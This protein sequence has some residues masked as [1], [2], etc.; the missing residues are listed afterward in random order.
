MRGRMR[1]CT[2]VCVCVRVGARARAHS[3][4]RA[5]ACAAAFDA[6]KPTRELLA[7]GELLPP[8]SSP[9]LPS[10]ILRHAAA[11]SAVRA[12]ATAIGAAERFHEG[13]S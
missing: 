8:R 3:C 2:Y 4:V 13:F 7:S 12:I 10:G 9:P 5:R 11:L 6:F 1:A